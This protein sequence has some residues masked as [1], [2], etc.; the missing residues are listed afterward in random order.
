MARGVEVVVVA[1]VLTAS[2]C[3]HGYKVN[4]SSFV[5]HIPVRNGRPLRRG[6]GSGGSGAEGTA[7]RVVAPVWEA[8]Q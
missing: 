4:R 8:E 3:L 6:A 2:L 5:N 7:R 1:L